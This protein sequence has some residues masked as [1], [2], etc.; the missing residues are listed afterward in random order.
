MHEVLVFFL[1]LLSSL[2]YNVDSY[3]K[4]TVGYNDFSEFDITCIPHM[5]KRAAVK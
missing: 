3:E 5:E 4:T 2:F 1:F